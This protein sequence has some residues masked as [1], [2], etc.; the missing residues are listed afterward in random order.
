MDSSYSKVIIN[1]SW[2]AATAL[3]LVVVLGSF[4]SL[5]VGDVTTLAALA[6]GEVSLAH[7]FYYWKA[8]S[9]NRS[10]HAMK[11][12]RDFAD[13]YGIDAVIGL[14]GTVLQE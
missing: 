14:A 11:L 1:R 8:R 5:P 13:Q 10:K 12:V 7:G 3:T 4:L 9:E 6:W 2:T